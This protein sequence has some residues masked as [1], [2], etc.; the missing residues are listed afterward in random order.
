MSFPPKL[1]PSPHRR[2]AAVAATAETEGGVKVGCWQPYAPLGGQRLV[3]DFLMLDRLQRA[4]GR[5]NS[6]AAKTVRRLHAQ[7]VGVLAE[8]LVKELRTVVEHEAGNALDWYLIPPWEV[9]AWINGC[10]HADLFRQTLGG[11][12]RQAAEMKATADFWRS[13]DNPSTA[14]G[15]SWWW[16]LRTTWPDGV[17]WPALQEWFSAPFWPQWADAYGGRRWERIAVAGERFC[18]AVAEFEPPIRL[19]AQICRI[20]DLRHNNGFL[21]EKM[22]TLKVSRASIREEVPHAA[23]KT[24]NDLLNRLQRG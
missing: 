12:F 7:C 8:T 1:P 22:G 13:C 9:T 16:S 18:Y 19:A 11:G 10:R 23:V 2:H 21:C 4:L 6:T 24:V 20:L 14:V 17:S 15:Q 3:L 5:K